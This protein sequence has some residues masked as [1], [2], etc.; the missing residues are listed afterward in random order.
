MRMEEESS[1]QTMVPSELREELEKKEI[2]VRT[3]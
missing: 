1:H 3:E 2:E